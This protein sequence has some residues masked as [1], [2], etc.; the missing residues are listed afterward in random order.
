[1][2]TDERPIWLVRAIDGTDDHRDHLTVPAALPHMQRTP[3]AFV[4]GVPL[5][6]PGPDVRGPR[7]HSLRVAD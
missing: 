6:P 7:Q 1:M 2:R 3:A 4:T 5:S